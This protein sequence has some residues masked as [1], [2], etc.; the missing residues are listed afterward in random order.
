[1][2][3][4][5][6]GPGIETAWNRTPAME[7]ETPLQPSQRDRYSRQLL[8]DSISEAAQQALLSSRV[9]VAGAGGLGSPVIQYLA[10]AGVGTIGIADGGTVKRSN[11]QR[12]V[13]YGVE[14][15]GEPKAERA[16]RFVRALNPDVS[17]ETHQGLIE[18]DD[19]EALVSDYEIVVDGLDNFPTRFLLNDAARIAEVPFVHGAIYGFEGQAS[20]FR[21]GGPCY[22]CL[23]P[24]APKPG[25]VPSDE[26]M[27]VFPTV[28]GTIGT[29]QAT[30]T[31]KL[32][33][34]IGTT[35]DGR[36]LRYDATD[37][38]F[39]STPLERTPD[40]SVCGPDGIETTDGID[41]TGA[42]RIE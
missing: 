32:L 26:P 9:L 17:V 15:V 12:Q 5:S 42:C 40:C 37:V 22:R 39:V 11:L 3:S 34:G 14:D 30:E 41:Y 13:I 33:L 6:I 36:I 21:P 25:T 28:P 35:L 31:I 7:R 2:T 27:A 1:M 24:E 19:A 10:A 29:L 16:A 4:G 23:L 8:L 38:T 18:P 20:T